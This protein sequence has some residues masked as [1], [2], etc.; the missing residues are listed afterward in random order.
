MSNERVASLDLP[1]DTQMEWVKVKGEWYQVCELD[2]PNLAKWLS[3]SQSSPPP[4]EGM[5]FQFPENWHTTL[6]SLSLKTE[7]GKP[8][9]IHQIAGWGSKTLNA[10]FLKVR[11]LSGLDSGKKD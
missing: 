8:V 1:G 9:P 2:G 10:L 5:P 11:D 4:K 3:F 7:D 6:L